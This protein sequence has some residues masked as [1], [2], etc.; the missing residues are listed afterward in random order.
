MIN[1]MWVNFSFCS[2]R[3]IKRC[4][5]AAERKV[6]LVR[7]LMF[8]PSIIWLH[9]QVARNQ[10]SHIC[11]SRNE[12]SLFPAKQQEKG[13]STVKAW[14]GMSVFLLLT[15]WSP[16]YCPPTCV[17]FWNWNQGSPFPK[18]ACNH[19]LRFQS[20]LLR[21]GV[22]QASLA[23]ET[24]GDADAHQSPLL[25]L[26]WLPQ[27]GCMVS[28]SFDL[29]LTRSPPTGG[30]VHLRRARRRRR[31]RQ[32]RSRAS[33]GANASYKS[34]HVSSPTWDQSSWTGWSRYVC[35]C[36]CN[37]YDE[38]ARVLIVSPVLFFNVL[39]TLCY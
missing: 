37:F 2:G 18:R 3:S 39:S 23:I 30:H 26:R 22:H 6:K 5:A 35:S 25:P 28:A 20:Q 15:T 8:F 16:Q 19:D 38:D 33:S 21:E 9:V 36:V 7:H 27:S 34:I 4:E 17:A 1:I 14:E 29:P 12:S 11:I 13:Q 32:R 10:R 24:S 31:R